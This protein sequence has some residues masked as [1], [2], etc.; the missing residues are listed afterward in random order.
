[1]MAVVLVITQ[2][3]N[4]YLSFQQVFIAS[5]LVGT[6]ETNCCYVLYD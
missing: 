3:H 4:K 1:M 2:M 5:L 6:Q